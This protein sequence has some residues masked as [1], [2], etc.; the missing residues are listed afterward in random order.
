MRALIAD[1]GLREA[2]RRAALAQA[3]RFDWSET[4]R[5]TL[6]AYRRVTAE[7]G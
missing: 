6:A 5:Q 7:E 1:R 4:A 2:K 3:A